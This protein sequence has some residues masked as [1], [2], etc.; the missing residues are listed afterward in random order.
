MKWPSI[1]KQIIN[2]TKN[3]RDVNIQS[4]LSKCQG[5]LEGNTCWGIHLLDRDL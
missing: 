2:I 1:A 3:K 4:F 5:S